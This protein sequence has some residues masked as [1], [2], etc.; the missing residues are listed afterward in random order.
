M[1]RTARFMHETSK[2][3]DSFRILFIPMKGNLTGNFGQ[4]G[5]RTISL[6]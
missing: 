1:E 2:G 6:Y 5:L 3:L 4:L